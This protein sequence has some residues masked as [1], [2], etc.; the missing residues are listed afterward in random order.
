MNA[1]AD[2]TRTTKIGG[3]AFHIRDS[4]VWAEIHYLDSPTDYREYLPH[5][6]LRREPFAIDDLT[7]L[8]SPKPSARRDAFRPTGWILPVVLGL[9]AFCS[10]WALVCDRF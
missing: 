7:M 6:Q 10:L 9:L 1:M 5:N 4:Y 8:D 3:N 2:R